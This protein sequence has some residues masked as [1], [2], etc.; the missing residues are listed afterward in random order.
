MAFVQLVQDLIE[1]SD[2]ESVIFAHV[3][4]KVASFVVSEQHLSERAW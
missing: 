1:E 4:T 2:L 3:T